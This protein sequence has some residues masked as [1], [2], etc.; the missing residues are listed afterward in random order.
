MVRVRQGWMRCAAVA[1]AAGVCCA[2]AIDPPPLAPHPEVASPTLGQRASTALSAAIDAAQS[3]G[4]WAARQAQ[5]GWG[6]ALGQGEAAVATAQALAMAAVDAA[7]DPDVGVRLYV[8]RPQYKGKADWAPDD[9]LD[10]IE[11][12]RVNG[13]LPERVA[14]CIHGL[15]DVGGLWCDVVMAAEA[16]GLACARFDYRN[17]QGIAQSAADLGGALKGLAGRG[18]KRVDLIG[19]SMGGLVARD[20]LT[21]PGLYAGD[22]RGRE[23]LPAVE[24]LITIGT[25]NKGAPLARLW[26]AS[27]AREH[28]IRFFES[29][30]RDPR[31]LLGMFKDGGGQ[32]GEDLLPDSA[33]LKDLNSRPLPKGVAITVITGAMADPAERALAAA[34]K[35]N[36]IGLVLRD[37]DAA[38]IRQA[39]HELA[40]GIGDGL[41]SVESQALEGVSDTVR[42]DGNHET[43]LRNVGVERDLRRVLGLGPPGVPAAVP[44]IVE[45]L[46]RPIH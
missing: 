44:V 29:G 17:D 7:P 32:A 27:E 14:L 8:P 28:L 40:A 12:E 33:Y 45:R 19:H 4:L 20:V 5:A 31:V 37:R 23:G 16:E 42:M 24:R 18:V 26:W 3:A 22:G 13:A 46:K 15:N 25:P 39:A 41:V 2:A 6:W 38:A 1:L 10:W 34:T 9:H 36:L 30:A 21:R 35:W 11:V 43:I